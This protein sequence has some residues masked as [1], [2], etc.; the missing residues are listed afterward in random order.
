M[1][2]LNTMTAAELR[3]VREYLG[4]TGD[5][6]AEHLH[7]SPRT[8]RHWEHGKYAIPD[9]VRAEIELLETVTAD[10]VT[11]GV[12]AYHDLPDPTEMPLTTYRTDADYRGHHPEVA[13][14][15]SWH[16]AVCARIAQEVP[17]LTIIYWEQADAGPR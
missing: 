11:A 16:R 8:V 6:L 13:W 2:D 14:P 17:G 15:A 4:L 5:W 10:M 9:G 7:V 1:F 3:V 12:D